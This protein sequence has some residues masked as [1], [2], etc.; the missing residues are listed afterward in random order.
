M[1][2]VQRWAAAGRALAAKR[3]REALELEQRRKQQDEK[4]KDGGKQ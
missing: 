1:T 2:R 3:K 4:S